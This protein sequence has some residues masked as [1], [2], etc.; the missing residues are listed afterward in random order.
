MIHRKTHLSPS[1]R[2]VIKAG[3]GA[4]VTT[5]KTCLVY[6][7]NLE[8]GFPILPDPVCNTLDCYMDYWYT[9]DETRPFRDLAKII[10]EFP[11]TPK[12]QKTHNP[13]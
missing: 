13:K 9:D 12:H 1:V 7:T 4:I 11:Q 6:A 10:V 2:C 3:D 5:K 8:G